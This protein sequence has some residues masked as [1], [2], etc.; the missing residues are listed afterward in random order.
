MR[1]LCNYK[2][3]F[4]NLKNNISIPLLLLTLILF[5]PPFFDGGRNVFIG[6][7]ILILIGLLF[8]FKLRKKTA[9]PFA[10]S[11]AVFLLCLYLILSLVA[12]AFSVSPYN[13]F[14]LWLQNLSYAIL[15]FIAYYSQFRKQEINI[16]IKIFL[17]C[18]VALCLAGVYWYLTGD[19]NR[20]TSTFWWPN[21]FAGFLFF[22]MP[23]SFYSFLKDRS[24]LK[25]LSAPL[26]ILILISFVLTGS[27]GAFLSICISIFICG[28]IYFI[29]SNKKNTLIPQEH[30]V[31]L[32]KYW[33][34]LSCTIIL[35]TSLVFLINT[36]KADNMAFNKRATN[37]QD[38]LDTSSSIRLNYWKGSLEIFRDYPIFGSGLGSFSNIYP[39]YQKDPISAGKYAHNW[40]LEILAE[41]GAI[42]FI[43]FILFLSS[44]FRSFIKCRDVASQRFYGALAIGILA[45]LTH[46]AV[47]I[48]SHYPA[49]M[50]LFWLLFGVLNRK[51][52]K[53]VEGQK[54]KLVYFLFWILSFFLVI[55]GFV[56]LYSHYNFHKGLEYQGVEEFEVAQDYYAKSILL[57]SDQNYLRQYGIILYVQALNTQNKEMQE[58]FLDKALKISQKI[59]KS[60]SHNALNYELRGRIYKE[61]GQQS[62]AEKDFRIAIE[63]NKFTSR[64]YINLSLLLIDENR[65]KEANHLID[66]ILGIYS[67][68][69][70]ETRKLYILENQQTTSGIEKDIEYLKRLK[71]EL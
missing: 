56:F 51:E 12:V 29:Y 43:V 71:N 44:V 64:H 50:V 24:R 62:E 58:E 38:F 16:L 20:L 41:Q 55:K 45:F 5:L 27:R 2:N 3:M 39:K 70:V 11:G 52:Q 54:I 60:S 36:I 18:S 22:V 14:M 31:F 49:N 6:E 7:I 15:F 42:V 8:L 59:I 1:L 61:L 53:E 69:V 65:F 35:F 32:K 66:E 26:L 47:D 28:L 19:Y 63:L 30:S 13:S 46:N 33:L 23:L 67:P 40:Y 57:N 4:K 17:A 25:L 21:P 37:G 48:G 9:L 10:K 68:D 34:A